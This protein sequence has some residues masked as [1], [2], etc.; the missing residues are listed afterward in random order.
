MSTV[1][2]P[3]KDESVEAA[4]PTT[5]LGWRSR[6]TAIAA[7][8]L[9]HAGCYYVVNLINSWRALSTFVD[10]E[11]ALD[12]W[13]PF[14]EWTWTIYYLGDLYI[15][16][17]G[18]FVV[19]RM[20]GHWF[21]RAILTYAGMIV[22]GAAIQLALPASAP[23]PATLNDAQRWVHDLIAMRPYACLPS[24]HVALAVLP[25]ALGVTVLDQRWLK[26]LSVGLAVLIT[27]STVTLK[28]HFVLDA[29]AG[30]LLAL[31]AYLYWRVGAG[32]SRRP[33]EEK[34]YAGPKG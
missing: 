22:V 4:G 18:A 10:L 8:V 21:R 1:C 32:I 12:R 17:W 28:E 6:L 24:M 15:V 19:W 2:A 34:L 14:L 16:F 29:A 9:L 23:W 11:I 30:V 25:A 13:I 26:I 33:G 31:A 3:A 7:V 27:L 5:E 20:P